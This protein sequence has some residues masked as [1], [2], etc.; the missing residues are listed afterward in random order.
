MY[1]ETDPDFGAPGAH[2][3]CAYVVVIPAYRE[4]ATIA[5]VVTGCRACAQLAAVIV[6]DDGS[7]DLTGAAAAAAGAMVLRQPRNLGKGASLMRG[8][9]E[10]MRLFPES[11][12][13]VTLDGDG[14]HRPEDLPALLACARRHRGRIV[15]GSRRLGGQS[16]ASATPRGRYIA[17]RVAD[18]WISW[19]S[20]YPI[21]DSQ[22]GFRVYPMALLRTL[23]AGQGLASRFGFESEMLIAAGT[24]GVGCVAV[25]IPSIYGA[26]LRRASHFRPV[27]DIAKIAA[28]VARRL[29]RRGMHPVGLWRAIRGLRQ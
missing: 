29:L 17:N 19:A 24:L 23:R 21:D 7:A 27:V 6:V 5:A 28:L 11:A 20:G 3:A 9:A 1:P 4:A 13:V 18:F 14:Q 15:I 2:D 12:G 8:F 26:A 25:P 16:G 22:S 10:A